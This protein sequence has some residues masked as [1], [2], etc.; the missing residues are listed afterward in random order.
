MS[1]NQPVRQNKF[2]NANVAGANGR[3]LI[4]TTRKHH[5]IIGKK[6][7]RYINGSLPVLP[8]ND[9]EF[10]LALCSHYLF[11]YSE[12]VTLNQ[13]ILSLKELCRVSKEVRIYPLLSIEDNEQSKHLNPVMTSLLSSGI[14]TSLVSV[15]YEFQKGAKEM[16]VAKRV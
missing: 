9:D 7:G 14:S 6:A 5:G 15:E 2:N 10:E 1:Q 13:H 12:H 11:L 4:S 8:F 3:A 16:L